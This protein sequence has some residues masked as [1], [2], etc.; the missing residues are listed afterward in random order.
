VLRR[1]ASRM[2]PVTTSGCAL[3]SDAEDFSDAVAL[4]A[5]AGGAAFFGEP[6]LKVHDADGVLDG[7]VD[8]RDADGVEAFGDAG[9]PV[10]AAEGGEAE[11]DGF[12]ER[13]GGDLDSVF[14][15]AHVLN[16]DAAGFYGHGQR[17]AV[18]PFVRHRKARGRKSGRM[19]N[20]RSLPCKFLHAIAAARLRCHLPYID[21]MRVED[22][23]SPPQVPSIHEESTIASRPAR[24]HMVTLHPA[25]RAFKRQRCAKKRA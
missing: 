13:R 9:D 8:G 25:I 24:W 14:D 15:S 16:G 2:A 18:S 1:F 6:G 17:I 19:A 4:G 20:T 3:V 21:W 23:H 10:F 12:I 7:D 5:V 11:S 22:V